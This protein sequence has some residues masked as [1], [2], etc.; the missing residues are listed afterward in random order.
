MTQHPLQNWLRTT[1]TRQSD[2]AQRAGTQ[3]SRIARFL[4]GTCGFRA[5]LAQ[6]L[7]DASAAIASEK[8]VEVAPLCLQ[9]LVLNLPPRRAASA[10]RRTKPTP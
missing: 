1:G 5:Q 8:G 10:S 6:R 3:Q 9:D 7:V 2:L 4:A